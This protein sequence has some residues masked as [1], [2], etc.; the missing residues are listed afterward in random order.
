MR[1][2]FQLCHSQDVACTLMTEPSEVSFAPSTSLIY[3]TR[4]RGWGW[5]TDVLSR[6]RDGY[7]RL[8]LATLM[9]C[10]IPGLRVFVKLV[11]RFYSWEVSIWKR[12]SWLSSCM[13]MQ[14]WKVHQMHMSW[15]TL[16]HSFGKHYTN[17][18]SPKRNLVL[19]PFN[20]ER[21]FKMLDDGD[22]VH[23]D[24]RTNTT[25]WFELNR[26]YS[27][28]CGPQGCRFQLGRENRTSLL[29]RRT[30]HRHLVAW[31]SRRTDMIRKW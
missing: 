24:L 30:E 6:P 16:A 9:S 14:R 5:D 25:S 18:S 22:H 10:S 1:M 15:S 17:F 21:L 31:Q 8:W 13:T 3:T 7:Q 26:C 11:P 4:T 27:E 23:G 28:I 20:C 2:R 29:P 19:I 12:I